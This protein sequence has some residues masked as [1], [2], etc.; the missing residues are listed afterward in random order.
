MFSYNSDLPNLVFSVSYN[1]EDNTFGSDFITWT[2][3]TMG[4]SITSALKMPSSSDV[5]T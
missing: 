2:Y 5:L 1:V 3:D 4:N